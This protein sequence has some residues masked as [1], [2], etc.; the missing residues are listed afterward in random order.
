[1]FNV[2]GDGRISGAQLAD[3]FML[4]ERPLQGDR[5]EITSRAS[6]LLLRKHP[7][8]LHTQRRMHTTHTNATLTKYES[9]K[10]TTQK[11]YWILGMVQQ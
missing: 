9:Y 1:M 10:K 6:E 7:T 2:C 8:P 3:M 5:A 11:S 4:S